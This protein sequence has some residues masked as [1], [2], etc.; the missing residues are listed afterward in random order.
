MQNPVPVSR[1]RP[2]TCQ[3]FDQW[4]THRIK[5]IRETGFLFEDG[6]IQHGV[7][8]SERIDA[9]PGRSI[10]SFAFARFGWAPAELNPLS[11]A[12]NRDASETQVARPAAGIT[13]LP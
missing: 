12:S 13:K 5:F 4:P 1:L 11:C 10:R 9:T 7:N 3:V 8:Q 6:P 2:H